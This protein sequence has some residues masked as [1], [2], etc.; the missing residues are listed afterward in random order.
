M[1][2]IENKQKKKEKTKSQNVSSKEILQV[3][4]NH[5]LCQ[6]EFV[7]LK[8]ET[9]FQLNQMEVNLTQLQ[10]KII[11]RV[12]KNNHVESFK[13]QGETL[14]HSWKRAKRA[15]TAIRHSIELH[16]GRHC[17]AAASGYTV[18]NP[19]LNRPTEP[20]PRNNNNN[21]QQWDQYGVELFVM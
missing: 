11:T 9:I 4:L 19:M 5:D 18:R 6:K 14:Q 13:N 10:E 12:N 2:H 20:P 15:I 8:K 21:I 16:R 3:K 7:Q 1:T 17:I